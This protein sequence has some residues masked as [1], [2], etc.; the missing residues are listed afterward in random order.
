M[1]SVIALNT[2]DS[3]QNRSVGP[4]LWLKTTLKY[5]GS[6]AKCPPFAYLIFLH[7]LCAVQ[8]CANVLHICID[9][10]LLCVPSAG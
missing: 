5:L 6:N 9:S 7:L 2:K 1:N 3:P 10:V 8:F 4:S